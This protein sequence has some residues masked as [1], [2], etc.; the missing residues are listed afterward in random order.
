[1]G[2]VFVVGV[3]DAV[4]AGVPAGSMLVRLAAGS[5]LV[6]VRSQRERGQRAVD[7]VFYF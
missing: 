2:S 5:V 4:V 3:A 7:I 1:M 6:M